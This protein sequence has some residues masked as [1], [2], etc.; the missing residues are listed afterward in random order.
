MSVASP[1]RCV[2][3]VDLIDLD[4]LVAQGIRYILI[5]RDNTCVPYGAACAPDEIMAWTQKARDMGIGLCIVSNN[6][7]GTKVEASAR[8][9]GMN[10]VHHAMKPAPFALFRALKVLGGTKETSVLVGDQI[11]TDVLAGRLAGIRTILVRPQSEREL[12]YTRFFRIAERAILKGRVYEGEAA[13]E[14]H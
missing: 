10:V 1:W 5:D 12:W 11:F 13:G 6:F 14:A 8:E 3:R 4:D 9:L 7:H 2:S